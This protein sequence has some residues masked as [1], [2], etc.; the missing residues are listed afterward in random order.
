MLTVKKCKFISCV[1]ST[2]WCFKV[3]I[4][5]VKANNAASSVDNKCNAEDKGQDGIWSFMKSHQVSI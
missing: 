3:G 4:S 2:A 1:Q 5:A